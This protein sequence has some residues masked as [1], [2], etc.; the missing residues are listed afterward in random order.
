MEKPTVWVIVA[1]DHTREYVWVDSVHC[2]EMDAL[3][4]QNALETH[5]HLHGDLMSYDVCECEVE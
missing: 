3:D 1:Y 4:A 5:K 2:N